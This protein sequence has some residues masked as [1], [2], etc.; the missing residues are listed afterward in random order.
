MQRPRFSFLPFSGCELFVFS[1]VS[2]DSG[3]TSFEAQDKMAN[4]ML[5]HAQ[6]SSPSTDSEAF[7][8]RQI[9][10][11]VDGGPAYLVPGSLGSSN[12]QPEDITAMM[13][14]ELIDV[15]KGILHSSKQIAD[16]EKLQSRIDPAF[17]SEKAQKDRERR[18]GAAV[19]PREIKTIEVMTWAALEANPS[20]EERMLERAESLCPDVFDSWEDIW[21]DLFTLSHPEQNLWLQKRL[22]VLCCS[23]DEEYV[24][25]GWIDTD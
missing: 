9:E 4:E 8:A 18:I 21:E 10:R 3:L 2:S 17:Q 22:M 7:L 23:V 24:A 25:H 15:C 20:W 11:G 6:L 19:E 5:G 1:F 13:L 16:I 14:Q 12:A